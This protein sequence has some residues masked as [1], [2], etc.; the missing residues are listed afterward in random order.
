MFGNNTASY[1]LY[2]FSS[3]T[4]YRRLLSGCKFERAD[5]CYTAVCGINGTQTHNTEF[6]QSKI[7]EKEHGP[8]PGQCNG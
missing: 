3:K 7:S 5:R 2:P 1:H 4:S 6:V 8:R